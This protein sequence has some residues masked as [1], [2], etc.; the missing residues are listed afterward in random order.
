MIFIIL[1]VLSLSRQSVLCNGNP[2]SN[3]EVSVSSLRASSLTPLCNAINTRNV[4]KVTTFDFTYFDDYEKN[5]EDLGNESSVSCEVLPNMSLTLTINVRCEPQQ[6]RNRINCT[7]SPCFIIDKIS[8]V[9]FNIVGCSFKGPVVQSVWCIHCNFTF[10][11]L[12]VEGGDMDMVGYDLPLFLLRASASSSV[13][14]QNSNI[15]NGVKA[16]RVNGLDSILLSS[17]VAEY[18]QDKEKSPVDL[19][20]RNV[21]ILSS[22]FRNMLF[23]SQDENLGGGCVKVESNHYAL[24]YNLTFNN[25]TTNANGGCIKWVTR[26]QGS[27]ILKSIRMTQCKAFFS[28]GGMHL[29]AWDGSSVQVDDVQMLGVSSMF[30]SAILVV[31][32]ADKEYQAG[33]NTV[34]LKNIN[35]TSTSGTSCITAQN[36]QFRPETFGILHVQN[37][38][39]EGCYNHRNPF[40]LWIENLRFRLTPKTAKLSHDIDINNITISRT[41]T[42]DFHTLVPNKRVNRATLSSATHY[43]VGYTGG[44]MAGLS[45]MPPRTASTTTA[46]TTLQG[47]TLMAMSVCANTGLKGLS[48]EGGWFS[49]PLHQVF[50][51]ITG[52]IS[53]DSMMY[54]VVLCGIVWGSWVAMALCARYVGNVSTLIEAFGIVRFPLVPVACTSLIL[55]GVTFH[56]SR[57]AT[58]GSSDA[59]GTVVALLCVVL[60]PVTLIVYPIVMWRRIDTYDPV[61]YKVFRWHGDVLGHNVVRQCG[62]LPAGCWKPLDACNRHGI[63]Y[64]VYHPDRVVE[65]NVFQSVTLTLV[66]VLTGV[67]PQEDGIGCTA[68]LSLLATVCFGSSVYL[69]A[70]RPY[71]SIG[72]NIIKSAGFCV[73]GVVAL[74]EA[75]EGSEGFFDAII[76]FVSLCSVLDAVFCIFQ[77]IAVTI[78]GDESLE[79]Y[80]IHEDHVDKSKHSGGDHKVINLDLEQ[81]ML[82]GIEAELCIVPQSIPPKRQH[83]KEVC[84][85]L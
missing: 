54:N 53:V 15:H 83:E 77:V 60:Y 43:E 68:V 33:I 62:V 29:M 3:S 65:A 74:G 46:F 50:G 75:M 56:V 30:A 44:I 41:V 18:F 6:Q 57:Y 19:V 38:Q 48:K 28:A 24:G 31:F 8:N 26:D 63:I 64:E 70:R 9:T 17:I 11:G 76:T 73:N 71:L 84:V 78:W 20:A 4:S 79:D 51:P 34:T 23:S 59:L 55:Q 61:K 42:K 36:G 52:N 67:A 58:S 7:S 1:V 40:P 10:D 72:T 14:I 82:R 85:E 35:S 32:Y 47:M 27:A 49:S 80:C 22:T 81:T 13:I 25:C 45:L 21:T 12:D 5:I 37:V 2:N 66:G 69:C 39:L 16:I